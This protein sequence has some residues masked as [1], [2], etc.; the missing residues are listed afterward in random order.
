VLHSACWRN[1]PD[2]PQFNALL[3]GG[4]A[5][6]HGP[7][8]ELDVHVVDPAHPIVSGL[9]L[10][11]RASDELYRFEQDARGAPIHV[12]A[13][14]RSLDG[15]EDFPVVWTVERPSGRTVCIT[16]GHDGATHESA[17]FRALFVNAARWVLESA[18]PR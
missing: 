11:F 9:P 5:S 2:W 12:L 8:G 7:Y 13:R 17:E 4:G 18:P 16:L 14:G 10:A 3:V 15:S 1:W 6:G